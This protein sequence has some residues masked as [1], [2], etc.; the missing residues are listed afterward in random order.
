MF[1]CWHK[2]TQKLVFREDTAYNV[3]SCDKCKKVKKETKLW[4]ITSRFKSRAA[5]A[6]LLAK[7]GIGN[8]IS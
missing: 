4:T 3:L 2:Y 5:S 1:F 6:A 8:E 7:R